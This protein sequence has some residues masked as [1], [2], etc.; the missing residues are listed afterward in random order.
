[1]APK[2]SDYYTAE[3]L[4]IQQ[5]FDRTG[6]GEAVLGQRSDAV[7][8]VVSRLYAQ[9]F[10]PQPDPL[11]NFCL[12]AL[13]GYGRRELFPH[14]D[15]DL[16]FLTESSAERSSRREAV[17]ALL[18]EL[19]DLRL[20]I[21]HSVHTLAEC[22]RLYPDNLEFNVA[23]LDCRFLA[24]DRQLYAR[25]HDDVVP[26]LV[27]RD[28]Q[29]LVRN[30]A[31]VTRQR[32]AKYG[33]TIFHLEPNLKEGPGGLRDYHVC[34]WLAR[35]SE[36]EKRKAWSTPEGLWPAP[37]RA[38]IGPAFKFLCDTRCFLHYYRGRDDNQLSYECQDQAC[39][40]GIASHGS[41]DPRLW[42]PRLS[43]TPADWM[44][45]YFRHVRSIYLLTLRLLDDNTPARA[46]IY[47]LFQNWRSRL[48]NA[49]FSVHRETIYAR[50]PAALAQ[51]P[52]LVLQLFGMVARHGLELSREAERAVTEALTR[53]V[54]KPPDPAVF[55]GHFRQILLSPWAAKALRE[56]N[57]LGVLSA[58]F[59]EFQVIDSLVIR[60]FFH[61]YTVDEHS[62]MT[63]QNLHALG[64]FRRKSQSGPNSGIGSEWEDKLAEILEEL[65][66]P[67]LLYLALL[68][69]DVGK[70]MEVPDH[71]EGS[72]QALEGIMAR[73]DL[74]PA[75]RATVRFLIASHLEMSTTL[76]R[77]DIFDPETVREFAGKIE[78]S[79]RLKM[80]SLLT[81]ADI[82]SVNPEALTPWKTE[83]LWRLYAATA[84]YLARSVDK[85]RVKPATASA[86]PAEKIL[87]LL[88]ASATR[89][90]VERFLEGFPRRYLVTHSPEEIA[91]HFQLAGRLGQEP[92]QVDLKALNGLYELA[93]ITPDRPFLFA[94]ITG[95]LAAWGMSIVKA[96]AFANAAGVALDTFRFVDLY[97]TLELNPSEANRLES[98]L[99][100]VLQ[101]RLELAKLMSGRLQS[102]SAQKPK[103][104]IPTQL[105]FDDSSSS[106]STLLEL[107]T[108]DRPGLLYQVSSVLAQLGCNIEIALIDTEGEKVIDVFYLTS[109]GRKLPPE[110]QEAI[111]KALLPKL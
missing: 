108:H 97:R 87:P 91:R 1:M 76:Q 6:D 20:R 43:L 16:L 88:A 54:A 27:A 73:L 89:E 110:L 15:I 55:W 96:D 7:D 24:G 23:L 77:R 56:M 94:S 39:A 86:S 70:G 109:Q 45:V 98:N 40:R 5:E 59:P 74:A 92:V 60:D 107:I 63:I 48:S 100:D 31:D 26:H 50:Q 51:D 65:E 42:G 95:A 47:G 13:G 58:L 79:E 68:F 84:N 36:L 38:E 19:W 106:H 10:P 81:Y 44:R 99:V 14:S 35:I 37:W 75:E 80:L 29:D 17:A 103:V 111:E 12:A 33:D 28:H 85:E 3:S 46:G 105:R 32:H 2:L 49:D 69:H 67:E 30:L 34:R 53:V 4:K 82:K 90:E 101:G 52:A 9:F 71:I 18:R 64:L 66:R 61:R 104:T 21:G 62:F 83:L 72:L 57:R 78:T 22:G 11:R 93:L 25:L 102:T 8:D 41:A